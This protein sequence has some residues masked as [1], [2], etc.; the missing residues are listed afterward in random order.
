M[1]KRPTCLTLYWLSFNVALES[2]SVTQSY[3][4][5]RGETVQAVIEKPQDSLLTQHAMWMADRGI[6][7]P[8]GN[9]NHRQRTHCLLVF[10]KHTFTHLLYLSAGLYHK[11]AKASADI[12]ETTQFPQHFYP[13][14]YPAHINQ[15][16]IPWL[17]VFGQSARAVWYKQMLVGSAGGSFLSCY[18]TTAKYFCSDI[19]HLF[20]IK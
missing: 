2:D 19:T 13:Q 17:I 6:T 18:A 10:T 16:Q 20:A 12:L 14:W 3:L 11:S 4:W 1:T 9:K 5:P 8:L 15:L 7:E